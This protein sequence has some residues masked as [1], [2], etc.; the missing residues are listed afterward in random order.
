MVVKKRQQKPLISCRCLWKHVAA[1]HDCATDG[2][3][4]KCEEETGNEI[5]AYL[6][7]LFSKAAGEVHKEFA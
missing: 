3:T 4:S 1:G 7:S 5:Y 6:T 2:D